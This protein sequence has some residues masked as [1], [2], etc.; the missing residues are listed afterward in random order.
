MWSEGTHLSCL[1]R[2]LRDLERGLKAVRQ[3]VALD[4]EDLRAVNE[5][6][7]LGRRQVRLLELLRGGER[8]HERAVV[9]RNNDRAR[10]RLLA[11]LDEVALVE[12]LACVR[13]L[14]LLREVV[15]PDT[16]GVH[17]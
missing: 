16:A 8:R 13:R 9:A 6:C 3:E 5:R 7:D 15:V 2:P 10:S 1:G 12:P 4:V 14:E 17:D 11:L